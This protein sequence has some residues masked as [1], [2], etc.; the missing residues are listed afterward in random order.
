MVCP[1]AGL[2]IHGRERPPA[3]TE[4]AAVLR[5]LGD[6][7]P[8]NLPRLATRTAGG[9]N[10]GSAPPRGPTQRSETEPERDV[11]RCRR[12]GETCPAPLGR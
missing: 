4:A 7:P 12:G 1:S 11:E 2:P 5:D 9:T 6:P 3:S 10:C 8:F